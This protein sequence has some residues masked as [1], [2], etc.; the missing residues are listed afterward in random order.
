VD[1][2]FSVR[3]GEVFACLG[4]NGAGKTTTIRTILDLIRPTGGHVRV[5]GLDS[6]RDA[7]RIHERLGYLPGERAL[8]ERMTGRDFLTHFAAL[9]GGAEPAR[10]DALAERFACPLDVRI[11]SLSHG[12]KQKVALIQAFMHEPDLLILDEPTQGLDPLVQQQFHLLVEE[13][14][15]AGRTV[16]LSSHVMPEVERL[17]DRVAIIRDG[18]MIAVEDIGDLKA[19]APRTLEIHFAEPVGAETFMGLPGVQDVEAHSDVVRLSLQGHVDAIIKAA[20]RFE[21]VDLETQ[22]PSL[23]DAFLSLYGDQD[24]QDDQDDHDDHGDR[25]QDEA[26]P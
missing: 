19:R 14:A 3:E 8:Y 6:H 21:V 11:S 9:R 18:A 15:R 4:P 25:D 2:S 1:L 22:Q 13:H 26:S 17:A 7:T 23:E 5:F 16:L 10:I 12:N 20:A 24:D